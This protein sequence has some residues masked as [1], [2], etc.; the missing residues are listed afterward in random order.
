MDIVYTT[1]IKDGVFTMS[2]KAPRQLLLHEEFEKMVWDETLRRAHAEGHIPVGSI[3]ISASEPSADEPPMELREGESLLDRMQRWQQRNAA[4]HIA[5]GMAEAYA[6]IPVEYVQIT[7][8][9]QLGA[10]L[11]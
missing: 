1:E 8:E 10:S 5:E 3:L 4:R 6:A 9:V 2:F 7:A 11:L